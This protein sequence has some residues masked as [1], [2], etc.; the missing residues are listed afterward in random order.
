M[1]GWLALGQR[2]DSVIME[3]SFN[4]DDSVILSSSYFLPLPTVCHFFQLFEV[5]S[6]QSLSIAI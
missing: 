4:L 5:I 6:S 1:G 3:V 2:L